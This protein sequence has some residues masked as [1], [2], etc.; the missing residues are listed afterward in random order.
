MSKFI[1]VHLVTGEVLS[2]HKTLKLAEN[3]K[4]RNS[5]M[6]RKIVE[7]SK[8]VKKGD[9]WVDLQSDIDAHIEQMETIEAQNELAECDAVI[10]EQSK[11]PTAV[12]YP[13]DFAMFTAICK[14]ED[15]TFDNVCRDF[16]EAWQTQENKNATQT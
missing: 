4:F 3:A 1:L 10:A 13:E 15:F 9:L 11:I 12:E 6:P 5:W 2:T 8:S 16:V 7:T 14:S